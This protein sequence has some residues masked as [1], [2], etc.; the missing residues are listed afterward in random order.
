MDERREHRF[1]FL[2]VLMVALGVLYFNGALS[3]DT[4]L[5][6]YGVYEESSAPLS[7]F[8]VQEPETFHAV[9]KGNAFV[10]ATVTILVGDTVEWTNTDKA[11]HTVTADDGRFDSKKQTPMLFRDKKFSHTFTRAGSYP[12]SCQ[13]HEGMK[14]VVVVQ[15]TSRVVVQEPSSEEV[16]PE[17]A[18]PAK[19]PIKKTTASLPSKSVTPTKPAIPKPTATV[20]SS[21]KTKAGASLPPLKKPAGA[22]C[23]KNTNCAS[24]DCKGGSCVQ[25][26]TDETRCSSGLVCRKVVALVKDKYCLPKVEQKKPSVQVTSSR[27]KK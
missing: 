26:C 16:S 12:Y 14:G 22:K 8:V 18:T 17:E 10:P 23:T 20:A 24:N 4:F 5:A 21:A 2:I 6:G 3:S 1:L 19:L 15:D 9:M 13:I 27:T 11:P 7:G 25:K